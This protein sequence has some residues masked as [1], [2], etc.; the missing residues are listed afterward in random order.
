VSG[1]FVSSVTRRPRRGRTALVVVVALAAVAA[2]VGAA[3][4]GLWLAD[5]GE[6]PARTTVGGVPVGGLQLEEAA[7]EVVLAGRERATLP[8]RL[9]GPGGEE[10]TTGAK[11]G[12]EPLVDEAIEAARE[13]SPLERAWRRLGL[14]GTREIPLEYAL[15]PVRVARL[16]N[17][18]DER[19][20]DPP[21]NADIVVRE[22]AVRVRPAAPGTGVD[23]AALRHALRT[24]P[25]EV[26]LSLVASAPGVVTA[27]AEAAKAD[28]ERLLSQ[29]RVV[30]FQ[31]VSATLWPKRLGALVRTEPV[32]G[33]LAV[34]L[35]PRGLEAA[36]RTRLGRFEQAP[37]DA[38][39]MPAG[40]R[41]R[42]A[43]SRPGRA[44][45]GK[46]IGASLL[47]NERAQAHL[48]RFRVSQPALPTQRARTLGIEQKISE[49]T[50]YHSCCAPRVNNIH[51]GA[52]IIDG[53]I[54]LPGK[55]FD[56]NQ[57]MGQ[58]TEAR[59]FLAAPQIF[60]GRLEDAVGGGVSQ[61]ATTMYNAAFFGGMQIVTHQ[62]HEF[63]ISRYPMGRE[64]T[65]SWGGPELIWRN[66]W[67]AAV[68]VNMVYTD[69]SVT[70]RLYS[71][72]LGRKVTSVT[73]TPCCYEAPRTITV[74]NSSL[75]AGT[76][77]TVQSAG[78]S[79][80]TISY[81]R[82]VFRDGRLKRNERYTWRYKPENAIVE[83]GPPAPPKPKP[84]PDPKP[85]ADVKPAPVDGE[86]ASAQ[87]A[88]TSP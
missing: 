42:I 50:T 18:L 32:D 49:F 45:D 16:A 9:I 66:D 31:G 69:T 53:T 13:A 51:R 38:G 41:V 55:T 33:A 15:G 60:N 35:D 21:R 19:F 75:P 28:V 56:L 29:P 7:E 83:V 43:P 34:T 25:S 24:L 57:V 74:S 76:T 23:R 17:A 88:S 58:R 70:V 37:R 22:T 1:P 87:T 26:G 36:L 12:A 30:R 64:A 82:K 67:P 72:K 52:D 80:F 20:A 62:P 5:R 40:D 59:G 65:V 61:I 77:S 4:G 68:L 79:G 39:F 8:I 3:Y 78:P 6:I 44:L 46:A 47:R 48:A 10:R 54:V 81:T 2:V 86:Q 27:E 71:S 11:L 73:G 85:P 14:G 63:Y 84:K